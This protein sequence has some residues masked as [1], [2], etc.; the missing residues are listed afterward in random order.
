MT[1]AGDSPADTDADCAGPELARADGL[2][3]A[4]TGEGVA[5]GTAVG[6]AVGRTVGLGVGRGVVFG[7]GLGVGTGVGMGVGTGVGT[8]VGVGLGVGVV[9]TTVAGDTVV[10]VIVRVPAPEGRVALKE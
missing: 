2:G 10:W 3:R 5:V 8:G 9:T 1:G 6:T 4:T 7:V